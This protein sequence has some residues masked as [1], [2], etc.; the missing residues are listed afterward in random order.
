ME[1]NGKKSENVWNRATRI[2]RKNGLGLIKGEGK[3]YE[4]V[5]MVEQYQHTGN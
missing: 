5:L 2:L 1:R 4:N 3:L